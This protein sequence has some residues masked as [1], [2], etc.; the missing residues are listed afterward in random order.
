MAARRQPLALTKPT[1]T[2]GEIISFGNTRLH[3]SPVLVRGLTCR[4][5]ESSYLR[6]GRCD[7]MR[8]SRAI[9]AEA[10]GVDSSMVGFVAFG[11]MVLLSVEPAFAAETA[12]VGY[13]KHVEGDKGRTRTRD[14]FGR[15]GIPSSFR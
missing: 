6:K 5:G 8:V 14:V 11:P 12:V 10:L 1:V 7:H 3:S 4:V 9:A 2:D 15:V 13:R